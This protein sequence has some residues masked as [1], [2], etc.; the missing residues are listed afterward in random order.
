MHNPPIAATPDFNAV[1]ENTDDIIVLRDVDGRVLA[2]NQAFKHIT[3]RLFKV[4]FQVGMRTTDYLS[5]EKTNYW[6]GILS[7]VLKGEKIR[8]VFSYQFE[9]GET[10]YYD[11]SFNPIIKDGIVVGTSEFTR[12]ITERKRAEKKQS[13]LERQLSNAMEIARLGHWEY[14]VESDLF[15]FNDQ[16]YRIFRTNVEQAGG[17]LMSSAEYAKRFVHPSDSEMVGKEI[18]RSIE[19]ND[20][21]FS[22]KLEHRILYADGEVGYIT[23]KYFVVKDDQGKTVRTYGVNQDITDRRMAEKELQEAIL[24]QNEAVKAGNVGLWG[25]GSSNKQS[26]LCTG[27]ETADWV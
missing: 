23:V 27:M 4:D 9:D 5:S 11:I 15:T 1:I 7:R 6:E 24:R 2:M 25:L 10:R 3:R 8:E 13:K 21:N 17:Y 19:T 26:D 14:D 18:R 20:P 16:F 12:D 22:Q